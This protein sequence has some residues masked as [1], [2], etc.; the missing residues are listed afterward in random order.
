[1]L[2]TDST[3]AINI[4]MFVVAGISLKGRKRL[5]TNCNV[6]KTV[7]WFVCCCNSHCHR[8][9]ILTTNKNLKRVNKQTMNISPLI[10]QTTH[11]LY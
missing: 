3:S 6:S 10:S 2:Y 8:V 1:M 4:V 11:K 7:Q 9:F 5:L